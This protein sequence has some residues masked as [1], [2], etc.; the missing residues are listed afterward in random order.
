MSRLLQEALRFSRAKEGE[1][2]HSEG[3]GREVVSRR[4][5]NFIGAGLLEGVRPRSSGCES[6]DTERLLLGAPEQGQ[7]DP[8][9]ETDHGEVRRLAA[10]G[11]R[12]DD[13][14]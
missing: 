7:I 11:D 1:H 12:L 3:E 5:T 10:V 2:P 14:R 8:A 9:G 6:A 4:E 13:S